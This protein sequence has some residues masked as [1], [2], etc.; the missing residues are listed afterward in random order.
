MQHFCFVSFYMSVNTLL[1]LL[2]LIPCI[3]IFC[4]VDLFQRSKHEGMGVLPFIKKQDPL[5]KWVDSK[6]ATEISRQ[7]ALAMI[8]PVIWVTAMCA[9]MCYMLLFA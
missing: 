2:I 8:L 6:R 1:V 3:M 7:V 5:W 4:L 9:F